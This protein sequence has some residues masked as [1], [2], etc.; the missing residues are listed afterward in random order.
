MA[1][2]A[3]HY[4]ALHIRECLLT[5]L[6]FRLSKIMELRWGGAGVIPSGNR[7]LLSAA[8]QGFADDYDE[9]LAAY[10]EDLGTALDLTSGVAPPK[11]L[12]V[13]VRVTH[14]FGSVVLDSGM[15][16]ALKA[17]EAHFLKRSDVETLIRQVRARAWG[18]SPAAELAR[19][20]RWWVRAV[21]AA[22]GRAPAPWRAGGRYTLCMNAVL[23]ATPSA[24]T[25]P[26]IYGRREWLTCRPAARRPC[27]SPG[28]ASG[29]RVGRVRARAPE[30]GSP[31]PR[32]RRDGPAVGLDGFQDERCHGRRNLFTFR[33]NEGSK[34]QLAMLP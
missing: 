9:V 13:E 25:A 17:N 31:G 5:Y 14:D 8:E 1:P 33:T 6:M 19:C 27:F 26:L 3:C 34:S 21:R 32:R 20:P 24:R 18:W 15:D 28:D 29:G 10:A 7:E 11:D 16:L 23:F 2:L 22:H 4:A 12:Y 30:L